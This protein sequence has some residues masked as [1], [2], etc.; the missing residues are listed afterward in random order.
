MDADYVVLSIPVFILLMGA[1]MLYARRTGQPLYR[2]ADTVSNLSCGVLQQLVMAFAATTLVGAYAWMVEH[3]RLFPTWPQDSWRAWLACLVMV[4]FVYYWFHRFS[5]ETALGWA[6]HVVH[7]Q[8]PEYNLGVALRQGAFQPL[9]SS[10]FF[11]PLAV[12]G[13]PTGMLL[14]SVSLNTLYQFW[15]H[16]QVL[17][18]LGALEWLFNTPSHHRVHHGSNRLYHDK[19]YGGVLIIWDR[20]FGTFRPETDPVVYG[21]TQSPNSFNPLW[22]HL[23]PFHQLAGT[24]ARMPGVINKVRVWFM[25]P[26]WLPPT[27][28]R[29]SSTL[30]GPEPCS[31]DVPSPLARYAVGHFLVVVSMALLVVSGSTVFTQVERVV[32][33]LVVT[34]SLASLGALLDGR[35]WSVAMERL[36]ILGVGGLFLGWGGGS[37]GLPGSVAGGALTTASLVWLSHLDRTRP[38][39]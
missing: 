2:L 24:V 26:G 18:R 17:R 27:L 36:R 15:L 6:A 25:K 14:V 3:G 11:L 38:L 5:H 9:L 34:W 29:V 20:M 23:H 35:P 10:W 37:L 28:R 12:L 7:H 39:R 33:A 32:L 31:H 1:E 4:D 19:N 16:T 8:S 30:A 21:V 22:D 13:V